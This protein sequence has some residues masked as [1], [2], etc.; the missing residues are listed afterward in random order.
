M[1]TDEMVRG[2]FSSE[3]GS[4]AQRGELVAK[5]ISKLVNCPLGQAR[6]IVFRALTGRRALEVSMTP[7]DFRAG[8]DYCLGRHPSL[9]VHD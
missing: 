3:R 2:W 6:A 7:S 5:R 4:E 9:D 8:L 1:K